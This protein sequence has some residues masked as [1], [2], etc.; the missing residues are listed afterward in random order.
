MATKNDAEKSPNDVLAEDVVTKLVES[1]LVSKN[2]LEEI[3][4]KMKSGTASVEDWKLW[5]DVSQKKP[6]GGKNGAGWSA[7]QCERCRG[8]GH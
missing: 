2:K 4:A 3:V 5:I 8:R 7:F 6:A 1:G